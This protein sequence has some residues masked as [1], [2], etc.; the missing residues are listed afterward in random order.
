[1]AVLVIVGTV[2]GITLSSGPD[3]DAAIVTAVNGAIGQKSAH[4]TLTGTFG[5]EGQSVS[6]TGSGNF[7]FTNNAAQ[8]AVN[9]GVEGQQENLQMVYLGGTLYENLPQIGEVVPGKSWVALDLASAQQSAGQ[10]A[11]GEL[12]GDPLASLQALAQQGNTVNALGPSTVNGQSVQGYS[13]TLVPSAIQREIQHENIPAWLRQSVS[14]ELSG[15][16]SET[17]YLDGAGQLVR[18]T[19]SITESLGTS[20]PV[21]GQLSFDFSDYGAPVSIAAPPAS[22]VIPYSQFLQLAKGSQTA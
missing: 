18:T 19:E 7:D 20:G 14:K 3:A 15:S 13:V 21:T 22:D 5:V 9:I 8:L 1:V 10:G 11:A 2:L 6:L 12:G 16:L 17:V 4:V